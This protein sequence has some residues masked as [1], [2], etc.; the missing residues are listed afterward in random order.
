MDCYTALTSLTEPYDSVWNNPL[1]LVGNLISTFLLGSILVA[2]IILPHLRVNYIAKYITHLAVLILIQQALNYASKLDRENTVVNIQSFVEY[3]LLLTTF[4]WTTCIAHIQYKLVLYET[5][6]P[7]DWFYKY[8]GF[9]YAVS[10]LFAAFDFIFDNLADDMGSNWYWFIFLY[11]PITVC[12]GF[13]LYFYVKMA[14]SIRRKNPSP[15]V[16]LRM[17]EF[18]FYPL[19]L[20]LCWFFYFL[21]YYTIWTNGYCPDGTFDVAVL[22]SGVENLLFIGSVLQNLQGAMMYPPYMLVVYK[23]IM[24]TPGSNASVELEETA[25]AAVFDI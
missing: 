21:A 3:F 19:I 1:F 4:V 17:W 2:F 11:F 16:W 25:G 14:L 22:P 12:L 15:Q 10:G 18:F 13:I 9:S 7:D 23:V 5:F 6:M 8:L 20:L 24:Q